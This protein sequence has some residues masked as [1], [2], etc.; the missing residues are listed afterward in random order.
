VVLLKVENITASYGRIVAVNNVSFDIR[1][2]EIVA[3]IGPNGAGKTTL[4]R[5][6]IGLHKQFSGKVYFRGRHQD[7]TDISNLPTHKR[8]KLGINLVPEGGHPFPYLTVYQN[9]I[10][11]AHMLAKDQVKRNLEYVFQL[12]PILKERMGQLAGTLSGGERRMLA[13]ARALMSSPKI[14]LIDELSLGLAPIIV[15]RLFKKLMELRNA[16][17]TI[18]LVE[19]NAKNALEI[20]DRAY[21]MENGRIVL[22]G[23]SEKLLK[24]EAVIKTYLAI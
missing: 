22:E 16:G 24:S 3:I 12:F 11:G 14:L 17:V 5:T 20:A 8:V 6:I 23:S 19:Q 18:L 7:M 10:C 15:A 2:G 4:L 9:L 13:I 21:V 1:E